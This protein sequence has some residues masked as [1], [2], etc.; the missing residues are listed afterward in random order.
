MKKCAYILFLILIF[1]LSSTVSA[2]IEVPST[3]DINIEL[4][5]T[6]PK[7]NELISASITSY[8]T[9]IN[10]AKITWSLNGKIQKSGMGEKS[11]IFNSG[12]VGTTNILYISAKTKEG[13]VIER[14]LTIAPVSV[15]LIWQSD[16]FVPPFYKGKALYSHQNKITFIA[17]PHIF[18]NGKEVSPKNLI[19]TWKKN[20]S[21]VDFASGYGKNTYATE[22][23]VIS[24][25]L[26]IEVVVTSPTTNA[27][28]YAHTLVNPIEPSIVFYKKNPLYGIEFQTALSGAVKIENSNEINILAIPFFFGVTDKRSA[29]LTYIWSINGSEIP[30]IGSSNQVF[31][32]KEGTEG[33]SLISLSIENSNKI[34]QYSSADFSLVFDNNKSSL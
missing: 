32:K 14:S 15:D 17:L 11:F 34:L 29:D 20:G 6:N 10:S 7:P 23:A 19:Y 16:S 5:P 4:I 28:G 13:E 9:D 12:D 27:S 33:N 30:N 26:N 24:R 21:V 8:S 1:T 2:Q 31:R 25:A 3:T 18:E 22:G